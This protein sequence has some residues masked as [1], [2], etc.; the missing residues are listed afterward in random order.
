MPISIP[1]RWATAAQATAGNQTHVA[2]DPH[3][4]SAFANGNGLQLKNNNFITITAD[5]TLDETHLSRFLYCGPAVTT[6]TLP[7]T[8]SSSLW[9]GK[10]LLIQIGKNGVTLKGAGAQQITDSPYS[11]TGNTIQ[12]YPKAFYILIGYSTGWQV[13]TA[14]GRVGLPRTVWTGSATSVSESALSESG[15]GF[16][17][18][19]GTSDGST[20]TGLLYTD[21]GDAENCIA[22]YSVSTNL[23][24]LTAAFIG[25]VF[26]LNRNIQGSGSITNGTITRIKKL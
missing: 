25:G 22:T 7:N 17:S 19:T 8:S 12:A 23:V 1:P 16:Y 18:I 3:G 13:V 26:R 21:G 4:L 15:A 10:V 20:W 2:V 5:T 14:T 11:V 6:I 9:L 24:G